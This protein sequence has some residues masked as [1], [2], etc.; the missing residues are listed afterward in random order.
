[1]KEVAASTVRVEQLLKYRQTRRTNPE[2]SNKTN[3]TEQ[4]PYWEANRSSSSR[5]IPRIL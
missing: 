2:D 1:M 3:S 4:S 5:K